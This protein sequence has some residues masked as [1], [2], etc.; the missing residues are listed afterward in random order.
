MRVRGLATVA[1]EA[2]RLGIDT[3]AAGRVR[4]R[5]AVHHADQRRLRR[6][7]DRR[8]G[9][10]GGRAARRARRQGR[11]RRRSYPPTSS[12]HVHSR[13]RLSTRRSPQGEMFGEPWDTTRDEDVQSLQEITL[14][15]MRGIG[16]YAHHAATLGQEDPAIYSYLFK[17]LAAL[18]DDALGRQRLGRPRARVRQGQP[19]HD[20]AARRGQHRH[21]RPS[22]SRRRSARATG[23]ARRSSSPATTCATSTQLLKQTEGN[24]I[25]VYTHGE[26]LPAHGYPGLKKYTHLVGQLRRRV[27]GS[28]ARSSTPFPGAILMTTNCIQ[29]PQRRLQGP[30]LHQRPGRLARA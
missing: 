21:L 15:G 23:R 9:R 10:R 29:K 1:V 28:A 2:E 14:Y 19:A 13:P 3:L 18:D 8:E 30:H 4:G 20:G 27:A 17:A 26:M 24:G 6:R 12:H 25:N 16:A 5:L 7:V 11:G 22:R